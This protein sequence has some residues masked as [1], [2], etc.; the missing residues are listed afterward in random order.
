MSQSLRP[1]S[2]LTLVLRILSQDSEMRFE[3]VQGALSM[4]LSPILCGRLGRTRPLPG[5]DNNTSSH[6]QQL[7]CLC[8]DCF[9]SGGEVS[10]EWPKNCFG[11]LRPELIEFVTK[12]ELYSVLVDGCATGMCAK[13]GTPILK[14]W[15]FISSSHRQSVS[16]VGLRCKHDT[17]CKRASTEGSE[18]KR[19]ETYTLPLC[20]VMLSSLSGFGDHS[21]CMPC[22]SP[23]VSLIIE[24]MP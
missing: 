7:H 22:Q 10:F 19:T 24:N 23:R 9:R 5:M 21:P 6:S 11:W 4:V 1:P 17:D 16:L 14:K 15:R 12:H 13:D 2:P 20:K 3:P 18:T 8:G